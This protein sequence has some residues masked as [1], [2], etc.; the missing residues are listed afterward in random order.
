MILQY[1]PVICVY[2]S[3]M[4]LNISTKPSDHSDI[5][6]FIPL[7]CHKRVYVYVGIGMSPCICE[8]FGISESTLDHDCVTLQHGGKDIKNRCGL[9]CQEYGGWSWSGGEFPHYWLLILWYVW[10][11]SRVLKAKMINWNR[12]KVINGKNQS[13]KHWRIQFLTKHRRR[14]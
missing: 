14:S 11:I 6:F 1:P 12:D 9:L 4:L 7:V 3:Y 5:L 13:R 8:C 10:A 2:P